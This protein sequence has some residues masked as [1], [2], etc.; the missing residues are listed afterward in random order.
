MNDLIRELEGK[1]YSML[2]ECQDA[3]LQNAAFYMLDAAK[4]IK[5]YEAKTRKK[6]YSEPTS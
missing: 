2:R 6:E 4:C 1:A 5:S 3:D